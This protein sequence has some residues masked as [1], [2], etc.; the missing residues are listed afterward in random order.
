MRSTSSAASRK[1]AL[2]INTTLDRPN[3]A[4]STPPAIGPIRRAMVLPSPVSALAGT[5]RLSST[6]LGI[7]APSAGMV[8][9]ASVIWI[10]VTAKT[11]HRQ[12]V[13]WIS[14]RS[15]ITTLWTRFVTT[16]MRLRS[17]RSTN[18][19]ATDENRNAGR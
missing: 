6:R 1:D 11:S 15:N 13:G 18:T 16:R 3:H 19:P 17:Q 14:S 8:N 2:S 7:R 5:S 12:P 4:S 10:K 9:I